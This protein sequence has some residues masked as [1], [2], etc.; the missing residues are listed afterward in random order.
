MRRKTHD[1]T[2]CLAAGWKHLGSVRPLDRGDPPG[3]HRERHLDPARARHAGERRRH[4]APAP[5]QIR[6]A[7]LE[8]TSRI[9]EMPFS[10]GSGGGAAVITSTGGAAVDP[11]RGAA[12]PEPR[13][14]RGAGRGLR[15]CELGS[16]GRRA[17][18][19]DR[20]PAFCHR[21][22]VAGAAGS[23]GRRP[24]G[25]CRFRRPSAR[26]QPPR[27]AHPPWL[28]SRLRRRLRVAGAGPASAGARARRAGS[29]EHL[30]LARGRSAGARPRPGPS[31]PGRTRPRRGTT[32]SSSGGGGK[33]Q[34]RSAGEARST[35]AAHPR[36]P[37][38][39]RCGRRA[40]A[41]P[42]PRP[43]SARLASGQGGVAPWRSSGMPAWRV[44]SGSASANVMGTV[45]RTLTG[46]PSTSRARTSTAGPPPSPPRRARGRCG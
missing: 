3:A 18:V 11:P 29:V 28:A 43:A 6:H 33:R 40:R 41:S 31:R 2:A 15:P 34:V 24:R 9:A 16:G 8:L 12:Q 37:A 27:D 38:P 14:R 36:G 21:L 19:G 26:S 23:S 30:G 22:E 42:R 46:L 20:G 35:R 7:G 10:G 13:R 32:R 5:G 44:S 25:P 45:R 1:A 17:R 39:P 4:R